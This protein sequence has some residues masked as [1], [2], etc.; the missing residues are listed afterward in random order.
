MDHCVI[1][2]FKL[3]YSYLRRTF[4][5]CITAIDIEEGTGQEVIKKFWKGFKILDG[6]KTI[7]D[8]WNDVKYFT[9]KGEWKKLCPE[10]LDDFESFKNTVLEVAENTV[11]MAR[12]SEVVEVEVQ[13]QDVAE[14]ME[15]HSQPLSNK[16]LLA[17]DEHRQDVPEEVSIIEL[18]GLTSKILSE[19][20]CYFEAGIALLEKHDP[21]FERG[22]KVGVNLVRDSA[23][24]TE[25]YGEKKRLSS[26]QTTLDSYFRKRPAPSTSTESPSLASTSTQSPTPSIAASRSPSK[27]P[28]KKCLALDDSIYD[29]EDMPSPSD[30]LQ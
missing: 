18:Q 11:E 14:L 4:S 2:A 20:F 3:Y 13:P 8:T 15:F 17:L 16:E 24:Y 25:I 28:A 1:A 9:L 22:S 21:D 30:F 5:R 12:Q 10:L 7:G 29:V 23:C 19:V 27:F 26:S 6:I